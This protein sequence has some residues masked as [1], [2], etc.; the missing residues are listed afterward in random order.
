MFQEKFV[1]IYQEKNV[2]LCQKKN[3]KMFQGRFARQSAKTSS[4]ARS[5]K[6]VNYNQN[7]NYCIFNRMTGNLFF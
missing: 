7:Q 1:E 2:S 3:V 5:A 6:A 4:G